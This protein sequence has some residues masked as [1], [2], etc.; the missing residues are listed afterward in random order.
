MS[1][2]LE[3]GG[4]SDVL[5]EPTT[6]PEAATQDDTG[7]T[8]VEAP[9][10]AG[11]DG[12]EAIEG[13]GEP[14]QDVAEPEAS[15]GDNFVI[16][17]KF[18]DKSVEDVAR[19]YAELEAQLGKQGTK[20]KGA[21]AYE[22]LYHEQVEPYWNEFVEHVRGRSGKEAGE[23]P[24]EPAA[25]P[26]AFD[27]DAFF[28]DPKSILD[29]HLDGRYGDVKGKL[30]QVEKTLSRLVNDQNQMLEASEY[31]RISQEPGFK[32]N[33]SEIAAV[34]RDGGG[35]FT[36]TDATYMVLGLKAKDAIKEARQKG[37]SE[38]LARNKPKVK[39]PITEKALGHEGSGEAPPPEGS[40]ED[41]LNKAKA[42]GDSRMEI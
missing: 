10:S 28:A 6:E 39:V 12:S 20:L 26:A 11:K 33:E 40:L 1:E 32:E 21:E 19:S 24:V 41:M 18:K 25:K 22:K 4:Y 3:P 17:E 42:L 27:S 9:L 36:W 15:T 16:P 35:R 13:Q 29:K 31:A 30:A 2:E 5:E 14:T 38:G 8:S 23:A 37:F 34:R 7:A